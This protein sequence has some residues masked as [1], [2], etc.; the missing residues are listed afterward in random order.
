MFLVAPRASGASPKYQAVSAG[1]E[2]EFKVRARSE[3]E[4]LPALRVIHELY[5]SLDPVGDT[6][7][8]STYFDRGRR[9]AQR[10]LRLR[11]DR[12]YDGQSSVLLKSIALSTGLLRVSREYLWITGPEGFNLLD[13]LHRR[14]PIAMHVL[15][16]AFDPDERD[17]HAALATLAPVA[18]VSLV[19]REF[20]VSSPDIHSLRLFNVLLDDVRVELIEPVAGV[21]RVSKFFELEVELDCEYGEA[22]EEAGRLANALRERGYEP[23][24]RDKCDPS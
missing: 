2:Y 1:I 22:F 12:R 5:G 16:A 19:R 7:R 10:G 18:Q 9:L 23:T 6:H 3:S 4:L 8:T 13:P 11:T 15:H 14:L 20:L 17:N 21:N 24:I